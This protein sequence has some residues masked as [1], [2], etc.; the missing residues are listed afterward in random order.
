[1]VTAYI[2]ANDTFQFCYQDGTVIP[3]GST[4]TADQVEEDPFF[5]DKMILSG[6]YVKMQVRTMP[7]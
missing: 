4:I 3:S 2:S 1:M 7:T 5:G 6:I